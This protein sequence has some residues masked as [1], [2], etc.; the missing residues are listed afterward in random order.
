MQVATY[1]VAL[2]R[3]LHQRN[4][5]V[6]VDAM[7]V[8]LDNKKGDDGSKVFTEGCEEMVIPKDWWNAKFEYLLAAVQP[9]GR[10]AWSKNP[11]KVTL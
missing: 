2:E 5:L 9:N 11:K 8:R 3:Q 1:A 7:I 4:R 6:N 10:G